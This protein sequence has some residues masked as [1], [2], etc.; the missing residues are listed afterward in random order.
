MKAALAFFAVA[1]LVA[2]TYASNPLCDMFAIRNRGETLFFIDAT[3][4]VLGAPNEY[5]F[6][7]TMLTE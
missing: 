6:T 4:G 3:N 2:T 1:L 7:L 5:V